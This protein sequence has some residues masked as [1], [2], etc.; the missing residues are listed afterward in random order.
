MLI[1]IAMQGLW[2]NARGSDGKVLNPLHESERDTVP[3]AS[4]NITSIIERGELSGL[5]KWCGLDSKRNFKRIMRS[6]RTFGLDDVQLAFASALHGASVGAVESLLANR[7]CGN[8]YRKK[9]GNTLKRKEGIFVN[10]RASAPGAY[11]RVQ[12]E[13]PEHL[14]GVWMSNDPSPNGDGPNAVSQMF[15]LDADGVGSIVSNGLPRR[16]VATFDANENLLQLKLTRHGKL[17]STRQMRYDPGRKALLTG[18]GPANTLYRD[19]ESLPAQVRSDLGL[20]PS[21][22]SAL[23]YLPTEYAMRA[24]F[25][26]YWHY[27]N[28]KAFATSPD[29]AYGHSA[30]GL[31]SSELATQSALRVCERYRKKWNS[32]QPCVIVNINGIWQASGDLASR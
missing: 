2:G 25:Q 12:R 1:D 28:Y 19:T 24:F 20:E 30:A 5:A 18:D 15:F 14:T 8:N 11:W 13:V 7:D 26:N 16:V 3:L 9:I 17:V 32:D 10:F 27:R 29:G 22:R 31:L 21:R 4:N 6:A 23:A